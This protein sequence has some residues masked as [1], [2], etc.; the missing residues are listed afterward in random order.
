[1]PAAFFTLKAEAEVCFRD[2]SGVPL[3][4]MTIPA[5]AFYANM[6]QVYYIRGVIA[7]ARMLIKAP[8]MLY[9]DPLLRA[10]IRYF[11]FFGVDNGESQV[12]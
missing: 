9:T 3:F 2:A 11:D 5:A 8:R 4:K 10:F 7:M 6:N 12:K 1:M